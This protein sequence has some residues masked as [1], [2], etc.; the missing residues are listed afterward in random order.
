[1]RLLR[2]IE[3]V[4]RDWRRLHNEE[5]HGLYV[6]P[7]V[8]QVIKSIRM[9]WTVHVAPKGER[10]YIHEFGA[11]SH[12]RRPIGRSRHRQENDIEK[13]FKK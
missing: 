9:R 3:E 1:V 2:E 11:K 5:L 10:K 12:G 4:T 6:S 8:I 13:L 7:N